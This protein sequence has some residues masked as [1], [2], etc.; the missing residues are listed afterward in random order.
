M[1]PFQIG[2]GLCM[3]WAASQAPQHYERVVVTGTW[4]PAPVEE[5]DRTVRSLPVR[6]QLLTHS[7]WTDFVRLD[8]SLDLRARAPFA[9]QG[10]LSIRGATFGQTLVLLDGMR[11]N[12]PQTGHHNLDL[13]LPMEMVS[14]I[15]LL[16]GA[17]STHYGAD[18]VGG[19]VHLL[20]APPEQSEFL[21]RAA[22]GQQG[23]QQQRTLLSAS[24]GNW[25]GQMAG[26]RDFSSGFTPNRD[27]RNLSLAAALWR[28]SQ[29]GPTHLLAAWNDRPFG[30][31]GFYGPFP[32]WERTRTWY[33]AGSQTVG[34]GRIAAAW[35]R[36]GD[37]FLLYRHQ[38]ELYENRH[39]ARTW[40]AS[41]R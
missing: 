14:R 1:G 24:R 23:I 7:V 34:R 15:E 21:L 30:A 9:V 16:R 32:S 26:A 5:V 2:V 4:Q 20:T 41:F 11:L 39:R 12:D 33:A 28:E 31:S 13:P 36:H 10:D 3:A 22:F 25:S 37:H 35:R 38:P 6:S 18:A 19:V 8:P 40:Q 17:G 29:A 27:Y